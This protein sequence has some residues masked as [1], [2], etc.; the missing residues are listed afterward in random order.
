MTTIAVLLNLL[1]A[2]AVVFLLFETFLIVRDTAR[3]ERR[4]QVGMKRVSAART[5]RPPAD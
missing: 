5:E 3:D 1:M 4:W 2:A